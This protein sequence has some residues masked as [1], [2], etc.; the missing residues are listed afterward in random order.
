MKH[1]FLKKMFWQLMIPAVM[2][3]AGL[4]LANI[5]DSLVVGIRMGSDGLAAI[6]ITLPIYMIYALFYVGIGIG[7]SVEFAKQAGAGKNKRATDIFNMMME[8]SVIIGIV[9]TV[10]GIFFTKQVLYILGTVPGDGNIYI[11]AYRYAKILL[12]CAPVF[13]INTPLYMFVR[14]DGS[15]KLSGAGF[16]IGNVLDVLLNYLFVIVMNVGVTGSVW[17]TIIGQTVA[18]LIFMIHIFG[19]KHIITLQ[20]VKIRLKEVLKIFKIGF[21]S[22]NQYLSQFVFIVIS[23]RILLSGLG[24]QGV[25][26]FDVVMNVSYVGLLFFQAAVDSMQPLSGTFYGE[27]NI[28]SQRKVL[29]LSMKY[30]M[31]MGCGLLVILMCFA[32]RICILF[33]IT[34]VSTIL[35]GV[36]AVR[37]YCVGAV[38][39]GINMILS[40]YYQSIGKENVT[41]L[42]SIL[43]GTVFLIVYTLL[44]GM[45]KPE[46]FWLLFPATEITTIAIYIVS[47]R[48][49]VLKNA[50]KTVSEERICSVMMDVANSQISNVI[51]TI[52]EFCNE[53]GASGKQS[54]YV[55][56][57]V[58]EI[59]SAII[60]NA[61][62]EKNKDMYIL[63]TIIALEDGDFR[64]CIRDNALEFNPFALMT[65]RVD[66]E[67]GDDALNG[68][69][70]MMVKSKAKEFHYRR[71][72]NFN[73]LIIS[74]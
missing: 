1:N 57:T 62:M 49:S 54:Y 10:T 42:I 20:P 55:I 35:M 48:E 72:L 70:I 38:F 8:L 2:S 4:A 33:G 37:I 34:D 66:I 24:Y 39:A 11:L 41:Y 74:V 25:A 12:I 63:I 61:F 64:L 26:V 21:A 31:S 5:A 71:Y 19:R 60:G 50:V 44:F 3:S 28:K 56:M 17:S 30:G 73:T 7:G 46:L 27:G 6:G 29:A 65:K 32:K 45:F 52:E 22:S 51:E 23:N 13:F 14:N 69:G 16:V 68:L 58:E 40:G 59:C 15:P 47:E 36:P 9:F 67:D 43:R 18:I 53:F